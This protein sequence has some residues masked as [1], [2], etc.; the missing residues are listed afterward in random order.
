MSSELAALQ[1]EYGE[2]RLQRSPEYATTIGVY[3]HN[4]QVENYAY[5]GFEEEYVRLNKTKREKSAFKTKKKI[6]FEIVKVI[7][8]SK[9][10]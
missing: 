1:K 8:M 4:D 3:K 6:K 7:Y 9:E 5:S 2:W 10:R